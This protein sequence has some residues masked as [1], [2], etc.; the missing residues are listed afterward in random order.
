MRS[1]NK[2]SIE[3]ERIDQFCSADEADGY[4]F[5]LIEKFPLPLADKHDCKFHSQK[6][7]RNIL[8]FKDFIDVCPVSHFIH[9]IR[10]PLAVIFSIVTV[11]GKS[12]EKCI[13]IPSS[14]GSPAN[15]LVIIERVKKYLH[16]GFNASKIAPNKILEVVYERLVSNPELATNKICEF[17]G[18]E[19]DKKID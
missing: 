2:K 19:W 3:R 17:L 16:A 6:I 8:V 15:L 12:K 9:I 14:S 18:I 1:I 13:Y 7:P 10:N 4:F 5:S 11:N